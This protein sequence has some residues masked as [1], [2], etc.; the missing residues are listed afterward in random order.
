MQ[1][2]SFGDKDKPEMSMVKTADEKER[3]ERAMPGGPS[4]ADKR[5]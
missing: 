2:T 3:D 5:R 4:D 1:F